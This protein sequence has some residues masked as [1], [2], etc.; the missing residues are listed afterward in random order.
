[1]LQG[2]LK[3]LEV[4]ARRQDADAWGFALGGFVHW[5]QQCIKLGVKYK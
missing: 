4:Q 3:M 1:M 2:F 5:L